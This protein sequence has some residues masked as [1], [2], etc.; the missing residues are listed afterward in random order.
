[1]PMNSEAPRRSSTRSGEQASRPSPLST[2]KRIGWNV[3]SAAMSVPIGRAHVTGTPSWTSRAACTRLAGM[4]RFRVPSWSSAPQRPQLLRLSIILMTS[5]S[6]GVWLMAGDYTRWVD[7]EPLT[8]PLRLPTV[9]RHGLDTTASALRPSLLHARRDLRAARRAP[10]AHAWQRRRAPRRR[11]AA[12]G[13]GARDSLWHRHL[14]AR[15]AGGR[16]AALPRRPTRP[17]RARVPF[18]RLQE[19]LAGAGQ[20]HGRDRRQSPRH[21]EIGR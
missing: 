7:S 11:R 12:Q 3:V 15:D 21:Q 9:R 14:L 13:N 20:P 1:M 8:P 4:I 2:M 5:L 19:L 10:P 17:S 16:A 18:V 6:A